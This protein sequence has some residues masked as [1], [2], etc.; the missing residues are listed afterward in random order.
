MVEG[1]K[2]EAAMVEEPRQKE[3]VALKRVTLTPAVLRVL[4]LA[5]GMEKYVKPRNHSSR[6]MPRKPNPQQII[7]PRWVSINGACVLNDPTGGQACK[8]GATLHLSLIHI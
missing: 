1:T 6:S 2:V 3:M 8:N 4:S 7:T 5:T